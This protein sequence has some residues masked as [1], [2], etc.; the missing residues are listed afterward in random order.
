MGYH[1]RI[2]NTGKEM[3]EENKL[4]RNKEKL[5]KHLKTKFNFH[6]DRDEAG[7]VYF[8]DPGDE[9][10]VLFYD[11]EELLAITT[12]DHLLSVMIKIA[13]S[14]GDGSRV[15][16]DENETYKD[17]NTVYLHEDDLDEDGCRQAQKKNKV[18]Y[19]IEKIKDIILPVIFP[20]ILGITVLIL[21]YFN[22]LK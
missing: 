12:S 8:Y 13:E 17:I 21:K 9:E 3:P 19:I 4:I 20:I 22:I 10:N 1:I 11:G 16:G 14:F 2:T 7:E 15:V 6:E 18:S 5:S